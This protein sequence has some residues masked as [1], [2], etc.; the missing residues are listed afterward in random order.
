MNIYKELLE[1][2]SYLGNLLRG[3]ATN[4]FT[5]TGTQS[6]TAIFYVPLHGKLYLGLSDHIENDIFHYRMLGDL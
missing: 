3:L 2:G 6:V 5:M 1:R 4:D